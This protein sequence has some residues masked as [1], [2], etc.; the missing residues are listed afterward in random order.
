[1]NMNKKNKYREGG[2]KCEVESTESR[3]C[4][5]SARHPELV[6]GSQT[7]IAGV[8]GSRFRNEFG[9]T[10]Q[11]QAGRLLTDCFVPRNNNDNSICQRTDVNY[12][13]YLN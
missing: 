12:T 4:C 3:E 13:I 9:M 8:G 1:M 11:T 6:S 10:G 7:V 5:L 2:K